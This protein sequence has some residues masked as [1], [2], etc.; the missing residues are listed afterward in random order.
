MEKTK[1]ESRI[2][3]VVQQTRFLDEGQIKKGLD[4][5]TI[6]KYAYILHDKD[7]KED[8]TKKEDHWHIVIQM[9]K[10]YYLDSVAKWFGVE[11]QY[12]EKKKGH[13]AFMDCVRYLTHEDPKQQKKGKHFYEDSCVHANFDF[14]EELNIEDAK[15]LLRKAERMATGELDKMCCDV[16]TKGKTLIECLKEHPMAY[17][18]NISRLQ[19]CRAEYLNRQVPP[20]SRI[21]IYISG[22]GGIGKGLASRALARQFARTYEVMEDL[23]DDAL[24][25]EVGADGSTFEGYDGQPVI[26][27]NDCRS[28]ELFKKL[29][30]REAIYN[31]F[32]THPTKQ[33]QNIKYSSITLINKVNIINSVQTPDDFIKGLAGEYTD[34][35]GEKH[36]AED[37]NQVRR[38]IVITIVLN[39][40]YFEAQFNKGY[41]EDL[42]DYSEYYD[43]KITTGNFGVARSRLDDMKYAQVEKALTKEINDKIVGKIRK[44]ESQS[45]VEIADG[46]PSEFVDYG[47]PYPFMIIPKGI[48]QVKDIY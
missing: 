30:T 47:K 41:F 46:L 32:E 48:D 27:W 19:K 2:F 24:F 6:E 29:G 33:R 38:R 31:I 1:I 25:Y 17:S 3:E 39:K 10:S 16:L 12:V 15:V 44:E 8:G 40:D 7:T 21:N 4:H 18:K 35:N 5:K 28:Y 43:Y 42:D 14:R 26:I 20:R 13:G 22:Q 11:P 34:K 9:T 23:E 37:I 36:K 45:V